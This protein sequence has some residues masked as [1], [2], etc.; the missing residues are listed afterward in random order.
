MKK[1]Q[2]IQIQMLSVLYEYRK[3]V[4]VICEGAWLLA[5][6]SLNNRAPILVTL[7]GAFIAAFIAGLLTL[8]TIQKTN[9]K[10]LKF[11]NSDL[12]MLDL[13]L[14]VVSYIATLFLA[15]ELTFTIIDV[16]SAPSADCLK[17]TLQTVAFLLYIGLFCI[18]RDPNKLQY[19]MY[20]ATYG[21]TVILDWAVTWG[22]QKY[23]PQWISLDL[24][25][26]KTFFVVPFIEAMLLFIILDEWLKAKEAA[27][28][29]KELTKEKAPNSKGK[30]RT[31][32]K[33][34]RKRRRQGKR[35][36]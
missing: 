14:Y 11:K 27:K 5:F 35:I 25:F 15:C 13:V 33:Q 9:I 20:A 34:Q 22:M 21:L 18:Y 1:K 16:L 26:A 19:H 32:K 29:E 36:V 2:L 28:K 10:Q 31:Q 24:E 23:L 17:F 8:L 7:L 3:F 30:S 6:Y 4:C 12:A